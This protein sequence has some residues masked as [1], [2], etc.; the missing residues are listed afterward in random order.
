MIDDLP[1]DPGSISGGFGLDNAED[2]GNIGRINVRS[3][4][5]NKSVDFVPSAE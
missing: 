4:G 3:K 2:L 5:N 1:K